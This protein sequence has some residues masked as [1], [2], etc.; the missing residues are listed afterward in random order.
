METSL[1]ACT[2]SREEFKALATQG[3]V[4]PVYRSILADL[5]T[6]VSAFLRL[7]H[8]P[9]AFLLESVEGGE[10]M[11]RYSF[12]GA[13]P[14]LT[15]QA[16]NN[17]VTITEHGVARTRDLADGEDPLHV[18]EELLTAVKYVS[19]PGLPRFAG[20][21]VGYIGYDWARCLEPIGDDVKDDLELDEVH[22]LLTDTLCIFDHVK[23]RLIGLA[24]VHIE[25]DSDLDVLYDNAVARV[26][27]LLAA[28][29]VPLEFEDPLHTAH[30]S[31][32]K[33]PEGAEDWKS[34]VTREFYEENVRKAKEY[35]AAGD[36]FQVQIGQRFEKPLHADAFDVYRAL[37]SLNPSPYM[38][39][40]SLQSGVTLVGASP[41]ILV[42]VV[43]D[44]VTVRPIAGTRR[45]GE[46]EAEDEAL[47]AEL[48]SDEKERAEHIMLVDLGRNDVGR[49]SEY[50]TV[51]VDDLMVIERY[52]HVMHIVSHVTGRLKQ[53]LTPLGALR[54]TFPAG[55]LTG[56]PKVRS[57][58]IIEELETTRRGVYGGAI[59]Y[60]SYTGN[61]D[62]CIAIRTLVIKNGI[63][64]IQA[65][66]GVVADSTPEGEYLETIHKSRAARQAVALAEAGLE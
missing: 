7:R 16:K 55:T 34:N 3:N 33:V 28:L 26:N 47:A 36:I 30:N 25:P 27:E 19:L 9:N 54:A 39:F 1:F 20:G 8:M 61:L 38:F 40:L 11:A 12:L 60:F 65:S 35:I 56:A 46:T 32:P 45:R 41:E 63:A 2:P 49:V 29:R 50:G 4:V 48:L 52:S 31:V 21:A 53:G 10:R 64:Y 15:L 51:K 5:E 18:L 43:D 23:H 24:N 62:S 22:L 17:I 57:M 42:T 6:P 37:R 59:G 66:G 44:T 13:E 14:Y 58:Q